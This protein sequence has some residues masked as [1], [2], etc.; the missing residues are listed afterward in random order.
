[1]ILPATEAESLAYTIRHV[2]GLTIAR[3][4]GC[5]A[6]AHRNEDDNRRNRRGHEEIRRGPVNTHYDTRLPD[7]PWS[8]RI[9]IPIIA[10][11]VTA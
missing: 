6:A 3:E 7:L 4:G 1:M 8:R 11:A 5:S 10:A 2:G 9:Q